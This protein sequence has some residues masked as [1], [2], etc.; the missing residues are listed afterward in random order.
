[1]GMQDGCWG[2]RGYTDL[3]G[4]NLVDTRVLALKDAIFDMNVPMSVAQGNMGEEVLW[5][6]QRWV[7]TLLHIQLENILTEAGQVLVVLQDEL[8]RL[9][10]DTVRLGHDLDA[11]QALQL[12]TGLLEAV[13]L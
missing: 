11:T 3:L 9:L 1:M 12:K 5:V 6:K 10:E 2:P 8:Q 4:N 7:A 13:L